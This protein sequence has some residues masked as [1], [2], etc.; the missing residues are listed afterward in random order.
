M[1]RSTWRYTLALVAVGV[2][3]ASFL[4]RYTWLKEC[5]RAH[6][7]DSLGTWYTVYGSG[8]FA[9]QVVLVG[10]VVVLI[11]TFILRRWRTGRN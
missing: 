10:G 5:E 7:C 9:S 11:V 3:V 1:K 6:R 2:F 4:R 8:V